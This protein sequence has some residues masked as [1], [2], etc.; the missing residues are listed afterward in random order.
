[1]AAKQLIAIYLCAGLLSACGGGGDGGSNTVAVNDGSAQYTGNRNA[2]TVNSGNASTLATKAIDGTDDAMSGGTTAGRSTGST[3]SALAIARNVVIA[4]AHARATRDFHSAVGTCGGNVTVIASGGTETDFNGTIAFNN[5]CEGTPGTAGPSVTISGTIAYSGTATTA[6]DPL[7]L[8]F[9]LID[10][11]V[12]EQPGNETT[13]LAGTISFTFSGPE[14]DMTMS[15]AIRDSNG[16]TYWISNYTVDEHANGQY[17]ISGRF[18]DPQH[19]YVT[20]T[21]T[22]PLTKTGEWPSSGVIVITGAGGAKAR[23]TALSTTYQV[24]LDMDGN[25]D[26]E[27]I[28][29]PQSWPTP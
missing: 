22:T 5:Y 6:G 12:I 7:T 24:D 19:G 20:V 18:Y 1:M 29:T 2:A 27:V 4:Q 9:S 17:S 16:T 15:V 21:T 25:D 3:N 26:Y 10:F 8:S 23:L 14:E 28:G 13:V 11:T